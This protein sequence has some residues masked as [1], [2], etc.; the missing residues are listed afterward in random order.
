MT[1]PSF[2]KKR[3]KV[4]FAWR[5]DIN[6][7]STCRMSFGWA[8][9]TARTTGLIF[10]QLYFTAASLKSVAERQ[11]YTRLTTL[12]RMA[13]SNAARM[14]RPSRVKTEAETKAMRGHIIQSVRIPRADKLLPN[15]VFLW[16]LYQFN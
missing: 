10:C 3:A 14:I 4:T 1:C 16:F 2:H 5:P 9:K 11:R 13:H 7:A 12:R 15:A 8:D 6:E